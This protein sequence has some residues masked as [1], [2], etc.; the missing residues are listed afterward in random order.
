MTADGYDAAATLRR[1][2]FT[3]WEANMLTQP[4]GYKGWKL[5]DDKQHAECLDCGALVEATHA[6]IMRHHEKRH[7]YDP[8]HPGHLISDCDVNRIS[9]D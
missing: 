9:R 2:I 8:R 1:M 5:A 3:T 4:G 7:E 6:G